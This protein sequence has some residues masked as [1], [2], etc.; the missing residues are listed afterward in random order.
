MTFRPM[1]ARLADVFVDN[2]KTRAA[3]ED[4]L[5]LNAAFLEQGQATADV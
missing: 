1:G 5:E 2:L 3:V 4:G